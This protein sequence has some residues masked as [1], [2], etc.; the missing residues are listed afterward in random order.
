MMLWLMQLERRAKL[1]VWLLVMALGISL[2]LS[3]LHLGRWSW[4]FT[5][6]PAIW[7]FSLLLED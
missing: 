7:G 3:T 2:T 6:L 5:L 1:L 4:W